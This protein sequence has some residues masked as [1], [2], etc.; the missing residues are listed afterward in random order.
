MSYYIQL[1]K[2]GIII[3]NL[4]SMIGGFFLAS[5]GNIN[6]SLLFLTILGLSLVIAA[7]CI[8][9]NIID[10][11][12]DQYMNRTKNRLLVIKPHFLYLAKIY[13]ILLGFFG[14]LIF[15]FFLNF[16]VFIE[17]VI[18]FIFYVL[19]YTKYTKR[20]TFN[21]IFIGS[22]A[23][24]MPLVIGY[25]VVSKVLDL[26]SFILFFI[27]FIWQIP[28]FYSIGIRYI[29][30]YQKAKIP[31]FSLKKGII[32]TKKHISIYIL[33][34][35]FSSSLLTV[36]GYTGR[37]Y[38]FSNLFL[39]LIW[40]YFS[41]LI[42]PKSIYYLFISKILFFFSIVVIINLSIMISINYIN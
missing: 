23:G 31:I 34:F 13:S 25:C 7:S 39:N 35:L 42:F 9:N 33:L 18:A 40:F 2:P 27:S 17:V 15:Y 8:I 11:D 37:L 10:R 20:S 5:K 28:H 30:D 12:I 4:F 36:F 6:Y 32:V 29:K 19:F 41:L 38:F 26:C 16:L 1:I 24:A 22:I 14:F 3:G 21:S